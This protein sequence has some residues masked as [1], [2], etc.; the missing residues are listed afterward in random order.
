MRKMLISQEEFEKL[1]Q[2]DL[3][4]I[5]CS[6]CGKETT[7]KKKDIIRSELSFCCK[8]CQDANHITS[9]TLDCENCGKEIIKQPSE[10]YEHNFCSQSCAATFNN[11]LHP[12]RT[13]E[14]HFF[15]VECGTETKYRRMFCEKHN[16][17]YGNKI[18]KLTLQEA[19]YSQK[20]GQNKYTRI[21]DNSRALYIKSGAV[22]EKCGYNIHVEAC[23][24]KAI[25]DFPLNTLVSEI[26]APE[27]ITIL[28]RNCHWELDH[29][30]KS[31]LKQTTFEDGAGI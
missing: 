16:P 27:N 5:L 4:P 29:P 25:K 11:K 10:I 8:K 7:K 17:I 31:I 6:Q 14:K 30:K 20:E 18:Q 21:R 13:K 2:R 1:K 12:K 15:C 9:K 23:H 28:C 26:N 19:I 24:I 22:C 3:V